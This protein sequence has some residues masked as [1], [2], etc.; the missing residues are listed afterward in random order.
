MTVFISPPWPFALCS[1]LRPLGLFFSC[2]ATA[3]LHPSSKTCSAPSVA[4][5]VICLFILF[6]SGSLLGPLLPCC[7]PCR[8]VFL[9]VLM[10][11]L[12]TGL[13]WQ[14]FFLPC[15]FF[16]LWIALLLTSMLFV[17]ISIL[18]CRVPVLA[19]WTFFAQPL[20]LGRSLFWCPPVRQIARVFRRL[21]NSPPIPFLLV[22]PDWSS[23]AY[24]SVLHPAG[25][26]HPRLSRTMQ[27]VPRF[28]STAPFSSSLFT[29]GACVP[30]IALLCTGP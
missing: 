29:S 20:L 15:L 16:R 5:S 23:A 1:G 18:S 30:M 17:R 3:L 6:R 9:T 19:V 8:L 12:F 4:W 24:W 11:G 10:S 22:V 7:Y 21:T 27:F 13:T 28:F 26:L 14:L 25:R 2:C